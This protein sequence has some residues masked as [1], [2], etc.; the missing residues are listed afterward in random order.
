MNACK[1]ALICGTSNAWKVAEPSDPPATTQERV[2]LLEI[3]GDEKNGYHLVMS[4]K[5]CFIADS[6]HATIEDA[7]DTAHRLFDVRPDE[8]S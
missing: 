6:W 5:G 7:L 1:V 2:V 4:P 8:W 3:R